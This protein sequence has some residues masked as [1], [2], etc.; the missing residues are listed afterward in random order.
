[1]EIVAEVT[2]EPEVE[3]VAEVTVEPEVEPE[4][5]IVAVT[6]PE[7]A[8]AAIVTETPAASAQTPMPE[9]LWELLEG[10]VLE[11]PLVYDQGCALTG[12]VTREAL[13]DMW[14]HTL[15]VMTQYE[16]V[17]EGIV[18]Q[19]EEVMLA[20]FDSAATAV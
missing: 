7:E 11:Q 17:T 20:R 9:G 8:P 13:R 5:E 10:T 2:V 6:L 15:E 14:R 4:V 16:A 18:A 3:I 19:C 12:A 1:V